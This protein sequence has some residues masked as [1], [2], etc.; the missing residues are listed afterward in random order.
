ML[1]INIFND[2]IIIGDDVDCKAYIFKLTNDILTLTQILEEDIPKNSSYGH[3]VS[4]T[5]GFI[6]IGSPFIQRVYLYKKINNVWTR[7]QT[8]Y[9]N[10]QLVD[11]GFG[12][13]VIIDQEKLLI[14]FKRYK[15][16]Q[17]PPSN[18]TSGFI[19]Q[20]SGAVLT[21]YNLGYQWQNVHTIIPEIFA[22]DSFFGKTFSTYNN[23]L[24]S[25]S[26]DNRKVFVFRYDLDR[27]IWNQVL[28]FSEPYLNH[29]GDQI[30][31]ISDEF[32]AVSYL[33]GIIV[34]KNF[35][36]V[37]QM[38][39]E[40]KINYISIKSDYMII[41]LQDRKVLV[42]KW[43]YNSTWKLI[44]TLLNINNA[45]LINGNKL[46]YN[47]NEMLSLSNEIF[48]SDSPTVSPTNIPT[49]SPTPAPTRKPTLSPTF[50]V[51]QSRINNY[52]LI[53]IG[54]VTV[55]LGIGIVKFKT[56]KTKKTKTRYN[57]NNEFYPVDYSVDYSVEGDFI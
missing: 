49:I 51:T 57:T 33:N 22:S 6:A 39:L 36:K 55:V 50:L 37:T 53:S 16:Y 21:Y 29:F 44:D 54:M 35:I 8:F 38:N 11:G 3:S 27:E 30:F 15:S 32:L 46:I 23:V 31:S 56:K 52:L 25:S 13:K 26:S 34:Y 42:F 7:T 19:L 48:S 45:V 20:N 18:S 24:I 1:S 28:E 40:S 43:M 14:G 12:D 4:I 2:E 9:P 47:R 5:D 41:G 17:Y 10:Y